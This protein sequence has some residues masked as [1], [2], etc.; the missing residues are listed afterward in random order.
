MKCLTRVTVLIV[1]AALFIIYESSKKIFLGEAMDSEN[2]FGITVMFIAV[3]MNFF[4][5][6]V[7]FK[8]AK[9]ADSISLYAD[10]E[11]LRTDVYSSL[12]VFLGLLLI[13]VTGYSILDPIIAIIVALFIFNTG[14]KI[15]KKACMNLLDHSL[16]DSEIE[17]IKEFK[18]EYFEIADAKTLQPVDKVFG[19]VE[20]YRIDKNGADHDLILLACPLQKRQMPL[21]QCAHCRDKTYR[22]F[23]AADSEQHICQLFNSFYKYHSINM[24]QNFCLI[25]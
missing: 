22:L 5:S 8:V 17:K 20:L 21:V 19:I 11:H 1:F 13:K 23:A 24:L 9:E 14:Y 15:S 16:P 2:I 4:V 18:L 12:G 3:I 25:L 6:S 7:L 10:G